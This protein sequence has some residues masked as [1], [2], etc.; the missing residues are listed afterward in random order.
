MKSMMNKKDM[1]IAKRMMKAENNSPKHE[2][3][4]GKKM[5]MKEKMKGIKS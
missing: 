5:R 4:E 3:A 1:L 2:K